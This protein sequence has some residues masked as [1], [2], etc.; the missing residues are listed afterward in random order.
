MFVKFALAVLTTVF[1][2]VGENSVQATLALF[3][4]ITSCGRPVDQTVLVPAVRL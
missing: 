2:R 3:G 1:R 4:E